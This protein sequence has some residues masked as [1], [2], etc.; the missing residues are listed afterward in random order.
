VVASKVQEWMNQ[1]GDVP[2]SA[3]HPF[4]S[5]VAEM[6]VLNGCMRCGLVMLC[7]DRGDL[8]LA[9]RWLDDGDTT[10]RM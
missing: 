10:V 9:M 4:A 1:S 2:G 8:D 5:A 7:Q 6:L 3:C